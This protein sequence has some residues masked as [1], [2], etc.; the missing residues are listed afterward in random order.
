MAS[1]TQDID[2]I[3]QER[4]MGIAVHVM[5]CCALKDRIISIGQRSVHI[6]VGTRQPGR[7]T[8][9]GKFAYHGVHYESLHRIGQIGT[10][11]GT[12]TIKA[13]RTDYAEIFLIRTHGYGPHALAQG[14]VRNMASGTNA[15]TSD[16]LV[17]GGSFNSCKRRNGKR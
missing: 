13:E 12:V 15:L 3:L 8:S 1:R 9:V 14:T 4:L 16:Y 17:V 10:A 7:I 6:V 11:P 2:I 5:A